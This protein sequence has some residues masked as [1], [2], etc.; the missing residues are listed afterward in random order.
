MIDADFNSLLIDWGEACQQ[1]PLTTVMST[2]LMA[3]ALTGSFIAGWLADA[4]GRLLVLKGCLLL[5]SIVNGVFSF[6]AT[7][8][9]LL[10]ATLLFT[11]GAGCGGYMVCKST[12][13]IFFV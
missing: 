6:V 2:T 7:V 12:V 9:W 8:S 4:Y 3:G 5:I 13:V 1:S 10:S 11:L